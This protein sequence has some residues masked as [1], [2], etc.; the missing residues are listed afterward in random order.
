MVRAYRNRDRNVR[1]VFMAIF[2]P[3]WLLA[4]LAMAG[5]LFEQWPLTVLVTAPLFVVWA[6]PIYTEFFLRFYEIRL[7]DEG[8]CESSE[9]RRGANSYERNR[10]S[11]WNGMTVAGA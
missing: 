7:S 5:I 1:L 2:G 3:F 11:S 6:S 9:L 8:A 10:S 4:G